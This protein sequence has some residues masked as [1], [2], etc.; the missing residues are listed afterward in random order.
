[1]AIDLIFMQ[2]FTGEVAIVPFGALI[3]GL[4]LPDLSNLLPVLYIGVSLLA[5]IFVSFLLSRFGRKPVYQIG[6]LAAIVSLVL[7]TIGF[8]TADTDTHE[9]DVGKIL[10]LTGLFSWMLAAGLS[11]SVITW[12]FVA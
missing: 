2:Q 6:T 7:I 4:I 8:F 3:G 9:I 10:V 11:V 12:V 5:G 1:M